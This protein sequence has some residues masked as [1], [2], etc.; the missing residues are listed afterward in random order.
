MK[1]C[2]PKKDDL[3]LAKNYRGVT[4]TSKI[5]NALL[6]NRIEPK[7][8]NM[9]RKNQNG[10]RRNRSTTSQILTIRRILEGLWASDITICRLYQGLRFHLQRKD[11]TN[12]TSIRPT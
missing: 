7:I 6:R 5:Y 11:G 4:L 2:I 3:G 12:P 1:G 9:L 10:F 8:D